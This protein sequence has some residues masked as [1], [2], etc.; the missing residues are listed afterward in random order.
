MNK[1]QI[2]KEVANNN[3][4]LRL[5]ETHKT[6]LKQ[7][8]KAAIKSGFSFYDGWGPSLMSE[9][10]IDKHITAESLIFLLKYSNKENLTLIEALCTSNEVN[11]NSL[12]LNG[13]YHS[14]IIQYIK[15]IDRIFNKCEENNKILE[16]FFQLFSL[17]TL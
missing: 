1:E 10:I 9:D 16:L 8:Y 13:F 12:C 3:G 2:L 4:Q 15:T 7:L 14:N 5:E 11:I 17:K 6:T